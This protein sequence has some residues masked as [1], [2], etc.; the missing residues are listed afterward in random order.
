[1]RYEGLLAQMTHHDTIR[2]KDVKCFGSESRSNR[3]V[4]PLTN[5]TSKASVFHAD[6]I[7]KIEKRNINLCIDLDRQP[8]APISPNQYTTLR[9]NN[10]SR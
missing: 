5:M 9:N 3:Y 8:G 4:P 6:Q 7:I 10:F 2:L 1:M